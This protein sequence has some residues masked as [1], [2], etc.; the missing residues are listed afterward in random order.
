MINRIKRLWLWFA[1]RSVEITLYGQSE[2]LE[3]VRDPLLHGRIL[4]ARAEA[5]RELARL[6]AEYN[7]TLPPGKRVYW[8][9]A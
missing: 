3:C 5:R 8:G 9:M 4:L 7:A 2:C 1:I 6:R